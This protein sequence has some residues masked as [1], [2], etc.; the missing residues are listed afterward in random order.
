MDLDELHAWCTLLRVPRFGVKRYLTVIKAFG[1]P[2]AFLQ[3]PS[4]EWRRAGMVADK[5]TLDKAMHDAEGDLDWLEKT[6]QA[7]LL[8]YLDS[9]YPP[10]LKMIADPPPL[11]FVRGDCELLCAP[12]LAI[13]GS[14][15]ASHEGKENARR[16]AAY[17]VEKGLVI[18]SGLALGVDGA[19]H[20][21]A[22][23]SKNPDFQGATIAV[24]GTGPDRLYPS[25]HHQLALDIL[26]KGGSIVTE[27][28]TQVP[29]L[30]N[31]FPKRNRIIS[32]LSLGTLVVEASMKSG[33]L[34]TAR[35]AAE[36]NREVFAIPGSIHN[37]MARGANHLIRNGAKLVE[38]AADIFEE[39][40]SVLLDFIQQKP[41]QTVPATPD[42]ETDTTHLPAQ[43]AITQI[44]HL[45]NT[46]AI[47]HKAQQTVEVADNTATENATAHAA[48]P[49][50]DEETQKLWQ[51]LSHEPQPVD[52]LVARSGLASH[53]V[54][55]MLLIMEL[56]GQ[57]SKVAGGRFQKAI[58]S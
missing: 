8:T 3:Q 39:L 30:P 43:Q 22:L 34:I 58:H 26:D 6:P 15:N 51:A 45:A 17:L 33:S 36:Q 38:T 54:S 12:Q 50:M 46:G 53:V 18:T 2:R 37:P 19:A 27:M 28:P 31:I 4:S 24:M 40:N 25:A 1:S 57:V 11:L 7:T 52:V 5:A 13:V 41:M 16:F 47:A 10:L 44:I 9:R 55:S 20:L 49:E 32:G 56:N 14:R 23:K 35:L 48:L 29:V 42:N 21:G